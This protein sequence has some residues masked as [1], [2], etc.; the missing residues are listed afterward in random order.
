MKIFSYFVSLA[1]IA[2]RLVLAAQPFSAAARERA[3]RILVWRLL[4]DRAHAV[5]FERDNFLWTAPIAGHVCRDLF[6]IGHWRDEALP[7][8]LRWLSSATEFDRRTTIINVGAHIGTILLYLVRLSQ[9]RALACEPVPATFDYLTQNVRANHLDAQI[10]LAPVAIGLER[11]PARMALTHDSGSA[12]VERP[13][14]RQGFALRSSQTG[15]VPTEMMPLKELVEKHQL[16][17]EEV[18]LVYCDA[19]GS[20]TAV[21]ATG[22][23]LW[24]ARVPLWLEIWPEGLEAHGGVDAF[25]QA[26]QA[27]FSHFIRKEAFLGDNPIAPWPIAA[28]PALLSSLSAPAADTDILLVNLG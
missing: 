14:G 2:A 22:A 5:T 1:I 11:G 20:E 26:A 12:E 16:R 10:Q 25:L 21:I 7:G 28:L 13:A 27:H 3:R 24:Q 6:V 17:F 19:Q 18:G 23:P 4:G 15:T 8:L 9:K